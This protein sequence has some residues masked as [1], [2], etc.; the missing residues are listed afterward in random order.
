MNTK[1]LTILSLLIILVSCGQ[2]NY[3]LPSVSGSK[4]EVLVVMNDTSWKAEV[5]QKLAQILKTEMVA[6]P[7]SEPSM[8]VSQCNAETF[9]DFLKPS[10]N[11]VLVNIS[12]K[13]TAPKIIFSHNVWA[14]PQSV[15]RLQA[16]TEAAMYKALDEHGEKV[17]DFF[18][19][20]ERDRQIEFN[21]Q[22]SNQ[23]I[24]S[25]IE[26]LF[27]I[28]IDVP[29]DINKSTK[30]KDFYWLT[31][32]HPN[33]RQDIVIYSYPYTDKKTFTK[34]FLIAKRDSVMKIN[35]PG[36]LE[37]SYMSTELK[38]HDPIFKE[39]WVNGGYAAE[40]RGLWRMH[41]GAS[42]G[43]P[44]FSHT[45]L[46]EINQRVIT[47]EGYVFAPA[48]AKRNL[49]RQLEAVVYSAKLPQEINAIEEVSVVANKENK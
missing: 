10:R 35:I 38:Y 17:L 47:I 2:G 37:G 44:F 36:E 13:Y 49:I 22:Y 27:G 26:K 5:G 14:Q 20:T 16:P 40:I 8:R 23:N 29:Q 32:D 4:Y 12:D 25:E 39:V 45:R 19:R 21:K 18:I 6:L 1:L 3:S 15:V 30:A 9:T 42:M 46:D 48:V 41:N 7:Q 34:E 11:L 43:G 24:N 28:Q 33:T 31:N